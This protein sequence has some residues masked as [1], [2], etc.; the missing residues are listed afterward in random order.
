MEKII[1]IAVGLAAVA[2]LARVIW[3]TVHGQTDCQCAG[4]CG[5]ECDKDK[6]KP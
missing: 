5:Q 4:G 2:Y 3:K 1:L 6:Q